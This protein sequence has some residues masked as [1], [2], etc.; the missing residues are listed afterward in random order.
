LRVTAL[1]KNVFMAFL[2][3][4]GHV[5]VERIATTV[6]PRRFRASGQELIAKN[7]LPG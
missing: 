1:V 3:L 5:V 2:S 4:P 6:A 7:G